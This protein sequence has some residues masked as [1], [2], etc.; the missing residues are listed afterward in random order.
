MSTQDTLRKLG[1]NQKEVTVYFALLKKGRTTPADLARITKINRATVYNI[2]KSLLNFGLIAE[3]LGG[4]TLF[5]VP[6]PPESLTQMLDKNKKELVEKEKLIKKAIGELSLIRSEG[7]YPVPKI[8]FV[9]EENL[10]DYLYENFVRWNKALLDHDCTWWGFQ[11]HT[12][13]ENFEKWILW[14]WHTKEYQDPRIKAKLLS[15]ASGIEQK[16]EKKLARTK[17]DIRFVNGMNFTSS[18]WVAGD[19]LVM[20]FTKQHPFYLVEIHDATLA[21]N[22]REVFKRLWATTEISKK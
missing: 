16:M 5:L 9:E 14:T 12:L 21:H 4:K 13:V 17:R 7:A 3:D 11:D 22:M 18:L 10:E 20:V 2:A 6:L 15:N 1:L 19:Y 8:R